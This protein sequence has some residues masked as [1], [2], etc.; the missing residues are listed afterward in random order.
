VYSDGPLSK[1][2]AMWC[3]STHRSKGFQPWTLLAIVKRERANIMEMNWNGRGEL[4]SNGA[5]DD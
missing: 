4:V 5:D 3:G 2:K 1:I